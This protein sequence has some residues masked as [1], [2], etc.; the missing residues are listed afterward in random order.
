MFSFRGARK[1]RLMIQFIFYLVIYFCFIPGGSF[2][3]EP[4]TVAAALPAKPYAWVEGDRMI[5]VGMDILHAFFDELKIKLEPISYPWARSLHYAEAG[6]IDALVTVFY[7]E[8]RNEFLDFPEH[9]LTIDVCVI[10][11]KG[12]T[13]KFEKWD[14]LIGKRGIGITGDSQGNDFD[15]FD[16]KKLKMHRVSHIKAAYQMLE[17][18]RMDYFIYVKDAALIEAANVG[19]IDK[20]EVLPVPVTSQKLYIAFSKKSKYAEYVPALSKKI[21]LWKRNGK[22]EKWHQ[23]AMDKSMQ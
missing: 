5:G 18:G 11:S 17:H 21:K 12:K 15:H 6:E 7:T 1:G 8:E 14:D 23:S 10:V 3:Q 4:L 2:A 13:F 9:Y 22:I 16:K 19:Y 20:I